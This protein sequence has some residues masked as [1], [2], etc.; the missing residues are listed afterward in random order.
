ME[1]CQTPGLEAGGPLL[2][3]Q[4]ALIPEGTGYAHGAV[5][6]GSG[7]LIRDAHCLLL[8]VTP[9]VPTTM[10][11]IRP[12]HTPLTLQPNWNVTYKSVTRESGGHFAKQ[13]GCKGHYSCPRRPPRA[14]SIR[15]ST[16][17]PIRDRGMTRWDRHSPDSHRATSDLGPCLPLSDKN[18]LGLSKRTS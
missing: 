11:K 2:W 10:Y 4:G 15:R 1:G 9:I 5:C 6:G 17:C 3:G 14:R 12:S 8:K 7:S 13:I 16:P 18:Q